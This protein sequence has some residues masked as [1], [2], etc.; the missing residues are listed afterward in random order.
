MYVYDNL[1]DVHPRR[2]CNVLVSPF[3]INSYQRG[4]GEPV[5]SLERIRAAA[6]VK[7]LDQ[8]RVR[9]YARRVAS[10]CCCPVGS[11]RPCFLAGSEHVG[12]A[13]S[14]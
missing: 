5:Q 13:C 12:V 11:H 3:P 4:S 7:P 9:Y 1:E 6:D 2:I 8:H 10:A 14:T